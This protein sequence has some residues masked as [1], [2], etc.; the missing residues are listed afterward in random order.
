MQSSGEM[1]S[2]GDSMILSEREASGSRL[3]SSS[4]YEDRILDV[5]RHLISHDE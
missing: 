4:H 3:W 2:G 5:Q 1:T